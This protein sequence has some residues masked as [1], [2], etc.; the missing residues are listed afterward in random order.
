M[1]KLVLL[2]FLAVAVFVYWYTKRQVTE[3]LK[4]KCPNCSAMVKRDVR[5]CHQCGKDLS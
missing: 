5:T 4:R 1:N 3:K 2:I